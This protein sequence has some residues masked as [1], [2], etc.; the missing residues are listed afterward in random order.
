MITTGMVSATFREKPAEDIIRLC[1]ENR[2]SAVEWSENAH[3][4]PDDP[5]GAALLRQ[6]T[7][8]AGLKIAAY[9]SY[10]R[11]GENENPAETFQKSLVSAKTL[12]APVIR[13]WAGKKPSAEVGEEEFSR[14][15]AEASL[16]A[17]L[18][19]QNGIQVAFEWHKNTLTDTNESAVRLLALAAHPNLYCLWQPTD[20]LTI[21]Q[22][23]LGLHWLSQNGRLLNLH[24]YY[25]P[26]G[27]RHPLAEGLAVWKDYLSQIDITEDRY[28]LIEFVRGNTEQ[29]LADDAQAIN[30]LAAEVNP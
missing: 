4:L 23:K 6:K 22:R 19:E 1:V 16:I 14:L 10:Y 28:A 3:V 18:A 13:I 26:D 27:T 20:A 2:L 9:G 21:E 25:W 30:R 12:G 5:Q 8:D 24:V 29:Q 11:L 17:G 7:E 15:A